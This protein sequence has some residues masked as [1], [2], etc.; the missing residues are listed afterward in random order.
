M[1]ATVT[2]PRAPPSNSSSG[3]V[4]EVTTFYA[5]RSRR[6]LVTDM[7]SARYS[8]QQSRVEIGERYLRS[9]PLPA[10]L[11]LPQAIRTSSCFEKA[12]D[13]LFRT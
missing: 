8:V 6:L 13:C 1:Y 12:D 3:A 5:Q 7:G 11:Q 2:L 9:H 4:R 10:D